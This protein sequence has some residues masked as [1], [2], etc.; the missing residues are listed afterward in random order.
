M[1]LRVILA[2]DERPARQRVRTLL[3]SETDM[4]IVAEC[5]DGAATVSAVVEHRPDLLFLDVQMPRLN[6]FGVLE[7]LGPKA[8]PVV[9]FTTAHDEHAVRAFEVNALDYLLKPF[10]ESRFRQALERARAHLRSRASDLPD[11][12]LQALLTHLRAGQGEG[13]RLLV[14]NPDRIL[15]L[16]A[17]QVD[18]VET[19]GNYVVV[20]AGSER[21]VV[22]ETMASL[23]KRLAEAGFMRISRSVLVN[24]RRIRELQPLGASEYC[25]VMKN[26]ARLTMTCALRDLQARMAEF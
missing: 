14:K 1:K 4:E 12:R 5:E 17:G 21:H 11:A 15:F 22:R 9:I 23:E 26:G 18:H 3:E 7:V 10:K 6:G 25:V 20:H 13:P 19:A 8:M 2:D 16:S 24:L